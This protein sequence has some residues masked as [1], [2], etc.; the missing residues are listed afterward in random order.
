MKI[1]KFKGMLIALPWIGGMLPV[2]VGYFRTGLSLWLIL[3]TISIILRKKWTI[4]DLAGVI[5]FSIIGF[6]I[7]ILNDRRFYPY[8]GTIVYTVYFLIHLIVWLRSKMNS[9]KSGIWNSTGKKLFW[10]ICFFSADV[11]SIV[12]RPDIWY[13]IGPPLIIITGAVMNMIIVKRRG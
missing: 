2:F 1:V 9:Q 11:S 7:I 6:N 8:T 3:F 12:F 5:V 4:T 13:I 10:L